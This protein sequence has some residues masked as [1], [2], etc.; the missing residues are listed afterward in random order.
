M[1]GKR[2]NK[3]K[4]WHNNKNLA[5]RNNTRCVK[6]TV[7]ACLMSTVMCVDIRSEK[8]EKLQGISN[9]SEGKE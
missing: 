7:A 6:P 1:G 5:L 9:T 2:C 8:S 3:K 4:L